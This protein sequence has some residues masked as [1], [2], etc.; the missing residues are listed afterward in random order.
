MSLKFCFQ[1]CESRAISDSGFSKCMQNIC[2]QNVNGSM[3]NFSGGGGGDGYGYG[4]DGGGDGYGY[5]GG[6]I[7]CG[8]IFWDWYAC[9]DAYVGVGTGSSVPVFLYVIESFK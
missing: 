3:M 6:C 9:A 8:G 1:N 7:D 5:G 2:S 4:C